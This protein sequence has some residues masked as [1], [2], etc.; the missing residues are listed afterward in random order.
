MAKKGFKRKLT[1]LILLIGIA[2][3]LTAFLLSNENIAIFKGIFSK[4]DI[5]RAEVQQ[6]LSELG[7]RGYVTIAVLAMLQV[8]V[9][10]LPAEPV[11]VIAGISF[12]FPLGLLLCAIG[13][14]VGNT[15][16]FI[17][18][19]LYGEKLREYFVKN[20]HLDFDKMAKSKRVT[21]IVFIL[22]FL[23][24]IPYGMICFF[25]ASFGMKFPRY[26]TVTL[27]G[28][29]PSI[30]IGV[31]L[32][33]AAIASSLALSITIC[34]LLILV[35]A[36]VMIK[37]D[38][39]FKKVNEF[40]DGTQD[41]KF[42]VKKYSRIK[43]SIA[44]VISRIVFFLRGVKVK[45]VRRVDKL[46]TPSIVLSTHGSFIDFA[47]AGSLTKET[48]PN[49]IVA[50]L[51][52]YKNIV[53]SFIREFG[54]FPKSMFAGDI[55]SA[56]NCLS[57]IKGGGVLA[58]MPEARLSTAGKFEDIQPGT[59][60]F[61]KKMG[62]T[63]YSVNI[64]GNYLASPKWGDGLRRGSLVEAELDILFTKEEIREL[65]VEEIKERCERRLYYDD[66]KWLEEHPEV[67]Y[68]KKTL[69][70]GLENI[71]V[72]CPKCKELYTIRA[73]GHDIFCDRCGRLATLS[74]RYLF[75]TDAPFSDFGKWYDWQF[76]EMKRE[77]LD[78]PDYALTSKVTFKL[79]SKDG[80]TMLYT[81]GEGVC[82]L[83]REGLTYVGTKDGEEVTLTFP[84]KN[85]YRLLFGA[86]ES[87]EVYVGRT[88]HFFLPEEGRSAVSW[89]I[90]SL[91]LN[92]LYEAR[93]LTH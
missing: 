42:K 30:C 24:A 78:D 22:Y 79:P 16:I 2:I 56:K 55:E 59:Y 4:D 66:L 72:K 25:A 36:V 53:G 1:I 92:D 75:D 54:C 15:I 35:I 87:F 67:R 23:P 68:K 74:D 85:L 28:A 73:K 48:A 86:G 77:I 45:Y 31:G 6:M 32:G 51:Y 27:L 39:I 93:L 18:Y 57:V 37:R 91:I 17:L 3:G 65:S 33:H 76:E 9:A 34:A 64:G 62:V 47:Y 5:T 88:I 8:I 58:M 60:D 89:Y 43:L 11:Q 84:I 50:R 21:L 81:A 44:Y 26:I 12:G 40:I 13:V 52:F 19:K 69:A 7:I 82:T 61:I 63:V 70:E 20:I 90:A 29:I 14:F 71:L 80:H 49:F 38:A 83:N 46:E 41:G 10:F